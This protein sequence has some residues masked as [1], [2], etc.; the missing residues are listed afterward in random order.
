MKNMENNYLSNIEKL[1]SEIINLRREVDN[2]NNINPNAD[3]IPEMIPPEQS[4]NIFFCN[5]ST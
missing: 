5:Y 2:A 1:K 4:Y 3:L